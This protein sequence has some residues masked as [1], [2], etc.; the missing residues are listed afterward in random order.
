MCNVKGVD[1]WEDVF[2]YHCSKCLMTSSSNMP[3]AMR[4]IKWLTSGRLQ[5][6][7]L[8]YMHVHI[9]LNNNILKLMQQVTFSI[10]VPN[11]WGT[12]DKFVIESWQPWAS[13]TF[14][15]LV[16]KVDWCKCC[17]Q[18]M[19]GLWV[20]KA[21]R[22]LKWTCVHSIGYLVTI[23][24]NVLCRLHYLPALASVM[25]NSFPWFM[26]VSMYGSNVSS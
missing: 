19:F 6:N 26:N 10:D 22:S 25:W 17:L 24:W 23:S 21:W 7:L 5:F 2:G 4:Q 16:R 3:Q 15:A 13:R 14:C 20:I 1:T 8:H 12:I 18:I 11:I 9:R